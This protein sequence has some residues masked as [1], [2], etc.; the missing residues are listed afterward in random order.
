M[1]VMM[2]RSALPRNVS[3]RMRVLLTPLNL[4]YAG[5]VALG[6]VNL[7]LLIH[8]GFAWQAATSQNAAA[9]EGQ[10][11]SM[12]T[13][14]IARKPLQGLDAK[15]AQAT[16]EANEFYARRLPFADSEV[17][18]ELGVLAKKQG[19]KLTRVQYAPSEVMSGSAGALTQLRMDASLSG[20]YRAL[21][22][23]INGLERDRM[24]FLVRGV[25]LTGE[26]GGTVGLRLGLVTYLRPP[27]GTERAE[28][29]VVAPAGDAAVGDSPGINPR[30]KTG[31]GASR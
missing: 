24:F 23:F 20:D 21:M 28:K 30:P 13:A 7:Y 19:V 29:S 11:V 5:V 6:L 8:I 16:K 14:E 31:G 12:K 4:Y 17:V 9:M 22:L 26:Q 25:T 27:V 15:L 18:G 10:T 2:T 3:E 1:T